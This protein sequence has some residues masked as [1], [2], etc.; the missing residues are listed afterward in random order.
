MSP[1]EKVRLGGHSRGV[2]Q[3]FLLPFFGALATLQGA[4]AVSPL[5][6]KQ[7]Q[8]GNGRGPMPEHFATTTLSWSEAPEQMERDP[9]AG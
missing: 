1:R 9:P 4:R 7:Q 5:T 6:A 2:L 3:S 8:R